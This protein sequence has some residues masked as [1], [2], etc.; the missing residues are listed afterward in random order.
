MCG[1]DGVVLASD[2]SERRVNHDDSVA[3]QNLVTKIR[4]DDTRKFAWA[5]AGGMV[6]PIFSNHFGQAMKSQTHQLSYRDAV[7]KLADSVMPA[8]EEW[9]P[10]AAGP[11]GYTC[12][13]LACGAAKKIFR[14][15][16]S[17]MGE[18][19]EMQGGWCVAGSEF[20][21]ASF[22]PRRLHSPELSVEQLV[23]LAAYSIRAAHDFDSAFVNGLD[24]AVYRDSVGRFEFVDSIFYWNEIEKFDAGLRQAIK[25]HAPF[26]MDHLRKEP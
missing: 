6:A 25:E 7:N 14:N 10:N 20:N 23:C 4:I 26:I 17:R 5:Y 18:A 3:T 9:H 12:V 22:L 19:E 13:T 15:M 2:Q 8:Y 1:K 16:F 11:S 21:V 24:I